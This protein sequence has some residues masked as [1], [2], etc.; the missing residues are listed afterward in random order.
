[1]YKQQLAKLHWAKMYGPNLPQA[2]TWIYLNV[3][4]R[5]RECNFELEQQFLFF[6]FI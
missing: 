5:W 1:M 2:R 4:R 6:I 3:Y